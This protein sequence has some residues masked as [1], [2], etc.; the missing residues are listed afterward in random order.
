MYVLLHIESNKKNKNKKTRWST[1]RQ[2]TTQF[3]RF[4]RRHGFWIGNQYIL[5]THEQE[6]NLFF[7]TWTAVVCERYLCRYKAYCIFENGQNV[8]AKV[9]VIINVVR[10]KEK[11]VLSDDSILSMSGHI[12]CS[13]R[14]K[15][16]RELT[17]TWANSTGSGETALMR[18][19]AWAFA[20]RICY[21]SSF[22]MGKLKQIGYLRYFYLSVSSLLVSSEFRGAKNRL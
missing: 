9:N 6:I 7:H 13:I 14:L 16:P 3:G 2:T 20:V 21:N 15:F 19:L 17:P 18:R 22:P 11:K 1:F 4:G 5:C 12:Q 10:R 8:P